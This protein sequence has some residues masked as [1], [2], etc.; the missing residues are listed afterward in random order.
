[1]RNVAVGAS[2]RNR[3][4]KPVTAAERQRSWRRCVPSPLPR[5]STA[6]ATVNRGLG[7]HGY[8]PSA[9]PRRMA[10]RACP[11]HS[12]FPHITLVE[13][14]PVFTQQLSQLVLKADL[15]MMLDLVFDVGA[16]SARL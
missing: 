10:C 4:T 13:F 11:S 14:D 1:M 12:L 2:P 8:T 9:A 7:A 15:T 6:T 16:H 3:E 5:L